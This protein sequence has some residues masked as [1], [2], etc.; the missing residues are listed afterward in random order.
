MLDIDGR[1]EAESCIMEMPIVTASVGASTLIELSTYPFV[2]GGDFLVC[3]SRL[4]LYAARNS[5][6]VMYLLMYTNFYE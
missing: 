5:V 4:A 6:G 3:R 1:H 2:V